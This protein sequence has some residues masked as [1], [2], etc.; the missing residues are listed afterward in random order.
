MARIILIFSLFFSHLFSDNI[1]YIE[2]YHDELCNILINTSN[3]IDDYFVEGDSSTQGSTTYAELSTSVAMEV[4]KV[5]EKDLRLRLRLSLPKIQKNLRLILEDENNDDSLYDRTSLNDED[6]V[7]KSYYLRLEYL[8][9]I[10]KQFNLALGV[11]LRIRNGNLVPYFNLR[12]RL[13]F[14]KGDKLRTSF[15]NRFR[16]YSDGE[17]EEIAELNI[18]YTF[19]ST[20]YAIFRNQLS[21]SNRDNYENIYHDI[22][23]IKELNQQK[24]VSV[25]VGIRSRSEN[26]KKYGVNYYHVHTRYHHL[27]Y[28]KWLYYQIAPSILWREEHGFDLS[29]RLM[30]NFGIFFKK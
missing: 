15:Y 28:K 8:K 5:L 14:Y 23:F 27:F 30:L 26:V 22:S 19:N 1:N 12:S 7:D 3:S 13:D 10:K 21:Y 16:F 18:I 4:N 11:G 20:F 9:F 24:K 6:L 29:Y 17:S 25:G 2:K